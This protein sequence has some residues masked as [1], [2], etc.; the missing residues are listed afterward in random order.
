MLAAGRLALF[1]SM[2]LADSV[3]VQHTTS[4]QGR[5]PSIKLPSLPF[6]SLPFP[7][8]PF[9]SLPFPCLPF[10]LPVDLVVQSLRTTSYT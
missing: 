10:R 6:P 7:S 3:L 5:Q 9:P 1:Y 4:A 8:L 2:W